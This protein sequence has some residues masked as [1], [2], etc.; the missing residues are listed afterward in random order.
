MEALGQIDEE[1]EDDIYNFDDVPIMTRPS[2]V[3]AQHA[4]AGESTQGGIGRVEAANAEGKLRGVDGE[5][6]IDSEGESSRLTDSE[7]ICTQIR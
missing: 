6:E 7:V 5:D 2:W 3:D 1:G 4:D